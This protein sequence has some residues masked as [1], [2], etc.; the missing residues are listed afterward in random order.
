MQLVGKPFLSF[1]LLI[2]IPNPRALAEPLVAIRLVRGDPLLRVGVQEPEKEVEAVLR[3]LV[4]REIQHVLAEDVWK[5]LAFRVALVQ[6]QP[7]YT[8]PSL[9]PRRSKYLEDSK[10]LV[11][12][13]L[14]RQQRLLQQKLRQYATRA[15]HVH[16]RSVLLVTQQELR[17]PV[18]Q[19]DHL[20]CELLLVAHR[21]RETKVSELHFPVHVHKHVAALEIPVKHFVLVAGPQ[22]SENLLQY[23]LDR[24]QVELALLVLSNS[25]QVVL[26]IFENHVDIPLV[27]VPGVRF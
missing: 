10:D 9:L 6:R 15:P 21:S 19:G 12:L 16:R 24:L 20:W 11:G 3:D 5:R 23:H 26:H 13:V 18:P 7:R 2:W 25:G 1:S 4:L 17:R 14:P 27:V 8:R 22:A